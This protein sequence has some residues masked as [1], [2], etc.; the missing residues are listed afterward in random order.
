MMPEP[1]DV[2]TTLEVAFPNAHVGEHDA[3]K[4]KTRIR[5]RL[6]DYGWAM[7]FPPE[8]PGTWESVIEAYAI[9]SL[10]NMEYCW[11]QH[12]WFYM[13][14]WEIVFAA[15]AAEYWPMHGDPHMRWQVAMLAAHRS[16]QAMLLRRQGIYGTSPND[17]Q[18]KSHQKNLANFHT[19]ASSRQSF[20]DTQ[21]PGASTS[22]A[23]GL[24]TEPEAI[25]V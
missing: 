14:D 17:Q 22:Q 3:S 13:V 25:E 2:W 11:G 10:A 7:K 19:S 12:E 18:W 20:P 5:K 21:Q 1:P 23:P 15:A 9:G 6:R 24:P 16:R 4:I 8:V